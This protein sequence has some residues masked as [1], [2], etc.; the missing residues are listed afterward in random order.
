MSNP[1]FYWTLFKK[2]QS[3]GHVAE[4]TF[5]GSAG[6]FAGVGFTDPTALLS[7]SHNGVALF[8]TTTATTP[9]WG[10]LNAKANGTGSFTYGGQVWQPMP[11][12]SSAA[13]AWA[14]FGGVPLVNAF[15]DWINA[16]KPN[17]FPAF[18]LIPNGGTVPGAL[19]AGGSKPFVCSYATDDGT[20]GAVPGDFWATSLIYLVDPMNGNLATP[21]TLHGSAEYYVAAV[22]GNRGDAAGGK[23]A[24]NPTTVQS[25][26]LQAEAWALTFGTGGASPGVQLP[27]LSN[28]D[29]NLKDGI[30]DVYSLK[31]GKYDIC[32]FRFKVQTVFDGLVAAI[33]DA[34]AHGTFSLP[35]GVNAQ[36]WLE[37]PPSHCCL[38]VAVRRDDQMWPAY[39]A[40]PQTE[41]RIAQKNL[42]V[43]DVDLAA[44]SPNPNINWK[45]FT[46]GG[47]LQALLAHLHPSDPDLGVNE[48][49]VHTDVDPQAAKIV[50]AVPKQTFARWFDQHQVRGYSIS[51]QNQS[52]KFSVPFLDHVVL[53]MDQ[54]QNRL[55]VPFLGEHV[56]PLAMGVQFDKTR[57]KDG[58]VVRVSIE[59]RSKVP[60]FNKRPCYDAAEVV[61]G[62]FT[63]ELRFHEYR[64]QHKQP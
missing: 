38:K 10:V 32:G 40:S 9:L 8:G 17:D 7:M 12:G 11:Q 56:L 63:V 5:H 20:V 54:R 35:M 18:I 25:P 62:G 37:T 34:V 43:F 44:P 47:P 48:L 61:V 23:Y 58:S 49:I 4:G 31:P 27:S 46:V 6:G 39:D 59:H 29:I 28:L 15:T 36:T 41:R 64:H 16:G 19:D 55:L 14:D 53:T 51:Y 52:D 45:Y 3:L 60:V 42:V 24:A 1:S 2:F 13:A 21:S 30:Y 33:N 57:F 26:Q 50:L 22:I